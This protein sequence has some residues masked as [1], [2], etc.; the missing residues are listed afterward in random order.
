MHIYGYTANMSRKKANY[1]R[2]ILEVVKGPFCPL[3]FST[4]GGTSVFCTNYHKRIANLISVIREDYSKTIRYIRTKL[5]SVL[6]RSVLMCLRGIRGKSYSDTTPIS[7]IIFSLIP[8][9][10]THEV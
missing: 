4:T 8:E 2:R 5:S 1:E 3:V 10:K 6:L 7:D 9:T